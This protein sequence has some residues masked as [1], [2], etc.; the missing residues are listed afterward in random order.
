MNLELDAD[1]QQLVAAV[2]TLLARQAGPRRAVSVLRTA[3]YDQRL[4]LALE[5]GGFLGILDDHP[6]LTVESALVVMEVSAAAG[7]APVAARALVAPGIGLSGL[8]GPIAVLDVGLPGPVRFA[9]QAA[10]FLVADGE[11]VRLLA[12]EQVSVEPVGSRYGYRFGIVVPTETGTVLDAHPDRLRDWWRVALAAEVSGAMTASLHATVEF[13]RQRHQFGRAISSYQGVR[14]RLAEL[15]A[16]VEGTR[17]LTLQAAY[18]LAE[19]EAA[20]QAAVV[21]CAAAARVVAEAHQLHGAM[22]FTEE[23]DLHVW[24][25]R[26]QALRT[27]LGGVSG[28]A[29]A[30]SLARWGSLGEA[31]SAA[32]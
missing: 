22:G 14:H 18:D 27:E 8:D 11:T 24:T 30:L 3:G 5:A 25:T 16:L 12:R 32:S 15:H 23:T 29:R 1:Q 13:V 17:L 20:A 21:A 4:L 28:N 6:S 9:Q 10:T 2:R 31:A 19:P 7:L 26:L